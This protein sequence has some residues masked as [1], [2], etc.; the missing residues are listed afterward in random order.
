MI[1]YSITEYP[2]LFTDS[3]PVPPSERHEPNSQ[4]LRTNK[5]ISQII[6][7]A[8]PEIH[9]KGEKNSVWKF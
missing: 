9:G 5:E 3:P 8:V 7:L 2:V 6:K 4:K 1:D